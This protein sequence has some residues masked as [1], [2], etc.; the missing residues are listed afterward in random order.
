MKRINNYIFLF[1]S[2]VSIVS[3]GQD[4]LTVEQAVDLVLENNYGII[5]SKNNT[6]IAD[7][8]AS[9]LNSGYLPTV[10]GAAGGNYRLDN[11]AESVFQ[12]GTARTGSNLASKSYN[13]SLNV[14][15]TLFDGLGRKY[16]FKKLVETHQL[17][18]LQARETAELTLLELF[19]AYYNIAQLTENLKAL[20]TTMDF[21]QQRLKRVSYQKEYGQG[22]NLDILNAEVDIN[23]SSVNYFNLVQEIANAKHNL[24]L[25]LARDIKA[26]FVIDT[27]IVFLDSIN[28]TLLFESMVNNNVT[29]MQLEKELDI[30][31]YNYKVN[32]SDYLPV[33]AMNGSYGLTK[34][35][36]NS[37][38]FLNS[39]YNRGLSAG[40]TLNWN[41]FDGGTTKTKVQNAQVSIDNQHV[42]KESLEKQVERDFINAWET[43]QNKLFIL[44]TQERNL[45]T[46]QINFNRTE[47][48]NK[49]GRI[50]SVEYRQ[51]QLNL[52]NAEINKTFSKYDAKVAELKVLQLSGQLLEVNF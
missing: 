15:Y 5:I 33:V 14:N 50:T 49:V 9:S 42:K 10:T 1:F 41:V 48:L 16:N 35:F 23:T 30:A 27:T 11:Y 20:E 37:A 34:N 51:A 46:T 2:L 4:V 22:S 44:K 32:K 21:S 28:E 12:D 3:F 31:T 25:I 6:K 17:T 19:N 13:A 39:T 40:V 43:Y 18:E 38:S 24:N 26:E 47:E 8:N 36:N 7:N 52:L 45:R 29:M